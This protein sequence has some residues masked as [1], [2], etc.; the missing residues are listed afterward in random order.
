MGCSRGYYIGICCKWAGPP[1]RSAFTAYKRPWGYCSK[2][3]HITPL[4]HFLYMQGVA[5]ALQ[6]GGAADKPSWV[7]P[8][9]G[10]RAPA[11]AWGAAVLA[12]DGQCQP[13]ALPCPTAQAKDDI[14]TQ[15]DEA[16]R[17]GVPAPSEQAHGASAAPERAEPRHCGSA[18]GRALPAR[19]AAQHN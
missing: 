12:P 3:S 6:G 7:R 13:P 8:A 1:R 11:P 19:P 15:L 5:M 18:K 2:A 9:D 16:A 10:W 17:S 4:A 14:Q